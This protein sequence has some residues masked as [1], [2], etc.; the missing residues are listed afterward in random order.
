M[1]QKVELE[2]LILKELYG[3]WERSV[4]GS[5]YGILRK[6]D[7][8]DEDFFARTVE[9]LEDKNLIR[10]TGYSEP[11]D[12]TCFG[13]QEVENRN[14]VDS[15]KVKK[16][17]DFRYQILE[18][19]SEV[20][21]RDGKYG[22]VCIDDLVSPEIADRIE[23]HLNIDFLKGFGLLNDVTI[24]CYQSTPEGRKQFEIWH[25]GKSISEDF[26]RVSHLAP[27]QRGRDFQKL[28]AK[29]IE[30]AGWQQSESVK[31]SYEEIDVIIYQNREFYLIECKWENEKSAPSDI[32]HLFGKLN[33]RADTNGIFMSMSGFTSG[34]VE[35]VE[36][37]TNQKLIL[38]FG[39]EDIEKVLLDPDSF[40]DLLNEKYNEL[41]MKRKAIWK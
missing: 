36:N 1:M 40:D 24:G 16:Y 26:D 7:D 3:W 21:K 22:E 11:C 30:F 14:L 32:N 5:V 38:L 8:I 6:S 33:Q 17:Q 29:A 10:G 35:N 41:V 2:N 39:K 20:Y 34:A 13:I 19:L 25:K 37:L 28:I 27:Q 23:Y 15:D 31:T 12:I 9:E 4:G 18:A